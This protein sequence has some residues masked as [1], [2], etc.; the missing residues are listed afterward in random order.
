MQDRF[1]ARREELIR[2][3]LERDIPQL[4]LRMPA[5]PLRRFWSMIAHYHA[6]TWN[7]S[8]LA[9]ALVWRILRSNGTSA[10]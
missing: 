4:G 5:P 2:T 8:E 1:A 10:S 7:S 3:F 6:Q 9:R